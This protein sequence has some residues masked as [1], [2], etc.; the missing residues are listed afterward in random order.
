MSRPRT[1]STRYC[2]PPWRW[3]RP[4]FASFLR[5]PEAGPIPNSMAASDSFTRAQRI[6]L[7]ALFGVL[8][9]F[10]PIGIDLYLPALPTIAAEFK[11]SIAAVEH[12]LAAFF[13][14]LCLGQA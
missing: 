3:P 14:G 9:V 7:I 2:P 12:S 10:T 6:E 8:T 4:A 5:P 1:I 11:T 13:L